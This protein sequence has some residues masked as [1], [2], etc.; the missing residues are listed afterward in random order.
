MPTRLSAFSGWGA[1]FE[2]VC[3]LDRRSPELQ[4]QGRVLVETWLDRAASV[5]GLVDAARARL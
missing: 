5:R 3:E 1:A 4:G 2:L